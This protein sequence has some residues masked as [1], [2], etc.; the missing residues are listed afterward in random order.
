[1]RHETGIQS[2]ALTKRHSVVRR[3]E[4]NYTVI[5]LRSKAWRTWGLGERRSERMALSLRTVTKDPTCPSY[6]FHHQNFWT[7][8]CCD[9]GPADTAS[10]C[11]S[12][13]KKSLLG[14][15]LGLRCFTCCDWHFFFFV[16]RPWVWN[17]GHDTGI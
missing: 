11:F 2:E 5:H 17:A 4:S 15:G 16:G 8:L 7:F 3:W 12:Y 14:L 10:C 6:A 1:M 9:D 13:L